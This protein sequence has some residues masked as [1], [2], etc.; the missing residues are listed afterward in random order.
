GV[1]QAIAAY[2]GDV[3]GNLWKFDLTSTDSDDWDVDYKLFKAEHPRTGTTAYPQP[4]TGAPTLGINLS[5]GGKIMVYFGT[6]KYIDAGDNSNS[7]VNI[8]SFYAIV[9]DGEE[10]ARADLHVRNMQTDMSAEP[11]T[12]VVNNTNAMGG[13]IDWQNHKGWM[14]HFN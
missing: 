11:P 4:I 6:G 13:A 3:N 2:A 9:D 12:R 10:V 14:V 8:E 1:G 7:N 5:L